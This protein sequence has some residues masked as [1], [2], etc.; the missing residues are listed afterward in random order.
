VGPGC[1]KSLREITGSR[2]LG[3]IL[4]LQDYRS[5]GLVFRRNLGLEGVLHFTYK[6]LDNKGLI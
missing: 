2:G 3:G 4:R 1:R 6:I 5:K